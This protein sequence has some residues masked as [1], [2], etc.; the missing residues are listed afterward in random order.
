MLNELFTQNSDTV[1][2]PLS[3]LI[4]TAVF[5][6]IIIFGLVGV[7]LF[8]ARRIKV[9]SKVRYGFGGKPLYSFMIVLGIAIAIP[10]T[11][12]ASYRSVEMI[13]YARAERDVIVE[14]DAEPINED[15]YEASFLAFP[16]IDGTVW[17]GKKYTVTWQVTGPVS[18]SQVEKDRSKEN[19][20]YITKEL[21]SGEYEVIVLVESDAFRVRKE[22][23]LK[24]Q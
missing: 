5:I 20:S 22:E 1:P 19:P 4:L 24:L 2:V 9:L 21:P 23:S 13:N 14:V 7:I 18:F 16:T 11:L 12:F 10:M 8:L 6:V 15:L 3:V 17:A